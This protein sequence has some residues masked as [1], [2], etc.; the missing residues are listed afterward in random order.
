MD[1]LSF[2]TLISLCE[3][4]E[5]LPT[6]VFHP[7]RKHYGEASA[8]RYI[9]GCREFVLE[10]VGAQSPTRPVLRR[11]LFAIVPDHISSAQ[12]S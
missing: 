12:V 10:I 6:G 4:R 3:A 11:L 8:M 9:V 1:V 7:G 2:V 5:V